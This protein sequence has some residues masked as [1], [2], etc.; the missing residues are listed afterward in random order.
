MNTRV[1]IS[2]VLQVEVTQDD[3]NLGWQGSASLCPVAR[4]AL[5][6]WGFHKANSVTASSTYKLKEGES[7][8]DLEIFAMGARL[9]FELP[10]E[11]GE[12]IR[13]FDSDLRMQPFKFEA[14]LTHVFTYR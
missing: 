6:A 4:A 5:R 14:V 11:V 1:Q 12:Q 3:I 10:W 7:T 8:P 9:R 13:K 2:P